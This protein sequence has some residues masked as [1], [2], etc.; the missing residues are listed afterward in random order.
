MLEKDS[1]YTSCPG[2]AKPNKKQFNFDTG[3]AT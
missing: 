2:G 1:A 3:T